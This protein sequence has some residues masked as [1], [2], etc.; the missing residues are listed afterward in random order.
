MLSSILTNVIKYRVLEMAAAIM[1]YHSMILT[2]WKKEVLNS[3]ILWL[4]HMFRVR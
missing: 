2:N 4:Y 1:F 3:S